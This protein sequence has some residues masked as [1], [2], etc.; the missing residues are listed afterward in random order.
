[1]RVDRLFDRR[2]FIAVSQPSKMW[3]KTKNLSSGHDLAAFLGSAGRELLKSN[4]ARTGGAKPPYDPAARQ[5]KGGV[6]PVISVAGEAS[7]P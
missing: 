7:N 1:M 4:W 6:G 5:W 3:L 2:S